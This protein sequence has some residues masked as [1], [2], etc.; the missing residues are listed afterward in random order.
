MTGRMTA[1]TWRRAE[2]ESQSEKTFQ[3]W[4]VELA[5]AHGWLV[6]HTY[7]SRRSEPGFPD[8][9]MVR[10]RR[11]VFAELKSQKGRVSTPQQNWIAA[12]GATAVEVY[13][14]RPSDRDLI[15]ATLVTSL[16]AA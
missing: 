15:E 7:D 13:L 3:A 10:G 16:R 8:L 2:F 6:Y 1:A 4:L 5:E 9:C 14:W 12:L 11:V